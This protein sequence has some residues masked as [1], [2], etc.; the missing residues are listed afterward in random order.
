[1]EQKIK[2]LKVQAFDIREAIDKLDIQKEQLTLQYNKII[3]QMTS[4][5]NSIEETKKNANKK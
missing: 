2:E 4:I 5:K 3:S 1:M